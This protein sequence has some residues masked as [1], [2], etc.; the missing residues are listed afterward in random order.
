MPYK[1]YVKDGVIV[2]TEAVDLPDG[3]LV[4]FRPVKAPNGQH[5]PDV[6]RFAGVIRAD[7]ETHDEYFEHLRKKHE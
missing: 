7:F 1:G 3:T 2:T 6:E 4:E 5:H